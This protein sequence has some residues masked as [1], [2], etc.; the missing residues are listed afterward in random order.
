[1]PNPLQKS[2]EE[3]VWGRPSVDASVANVPP[4]AAVETATTETQQENSSEV[5][6]AAVNQLPPPPFITPML[7]GVQSHVTQAWAM[8]LTKL[9]KRVGGSI[10][11]PLGQE[12]QINDA[13]AETARPVPFDLE[14]VWPDDTK[15]WVAAQGFRPQPPNS[16]TKEM[17]GFANPENV[18]VTYDSTTRKITLTGDTTAYYQGKLIP[19]LVSGWVS[20]AHN[21]TVDHNYYLYFNGSA[22]VWATDTFPGFTYLMIASALYRTVNKFALRECHGWMPWQVHEELHYNVGTYHQTG[23]DLSGTVIGSTT[24]ANR[25]PDIS[26]CT[27]ADEDLLTVNAAL[28]SKSYSQRYIVGPDAITYTL[29]AADIVPLSGANPY[30][31]SFT[32]PDWG[33]TLMPANSVQS[34]WL[35]EVPTTADAGSQAL[36]HVFVQGQWVTQATGAGA[37]AMAKAVADELKRLPSEL[38]LGNAGLLSS[39]YVA[40]KRIV[41]QYVGGNWSIASEQSLLGSRYAQISAASGGGLTFV[42]ATAPITGTGTVADPLVMAAATDSVSGYM[43][44]TD[45]ALLTGKANSANPAFTGVETFGTYVKKATIA[46]AS[47]AD[48]TP[49]GVFTITTANVTGNYDGGAYSC[50]IKGIITHGAVSNSGAGAVVFGD[51]LFERIQGYTGTGSNSAVE[52][53]KQ[54]ASLANASATRDIGTITVTV[55]ET[56]EYIQTVTFQIDL[57]GTT[58]TTATVTLEVELTYTGFTT[59]PVIAAA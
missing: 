30:Y 11:Q 48:N 4:S 31:N 52:V 43:T 40:I 47:I 28:T 3:T 56:S 18:I 58:V 13:F 15:G 27:I 6:A 7:E 36:R 14:T 9:Y 45:H 44:S 23:G 55:V 29:A 46:K 35:Y 37:P 10:A 19:Q 20:D 21:N 34:I 1:M 59:A 2:M 26:A 33:Q 41:I 50:R 5:A 12:S 38:N 24:A 16:L 49:T 53:L 39:E 51:Y 22:F 42:S 8:W 54:T 17:T 32:S 57:S 25:R